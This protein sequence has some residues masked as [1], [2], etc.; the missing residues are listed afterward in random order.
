MV[1]SNYPTETLT[2]RIIGEASKKDRRSRDLGHI[3]MSDLC[4]SK[5]WKHLVRKTSLRICNPFWALESCV[6][7][8]YIRALKF[9]LRPVAET[10]TTVVNPSRKRNTD[11]LEDVQNS[12]IRKLMIKYYSNDNNLI[13]NGSQLSDVFGLPSLN[14]REKLPIL[15]WWMK[16]F[17]RSYQSTGRF[18]LWDAERNHKRK[19]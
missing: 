3:I 15:S 14:N 1:E 19:A 13:S 10:G 16:K 5:H 11:L 12:C 7:E 8:I 2:Y 17:P 9:Y 4:F 18:L 6:P